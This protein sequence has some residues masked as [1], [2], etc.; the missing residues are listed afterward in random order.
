MCDPH[1]FNNNIL[2]LTEHKSKSIAF[3]QIAKSTYSKVSKSNLEKNSEKMDGILTTS[4]KIA[5]NDWKK[6]RKDTLWQNHF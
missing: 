3:L 2:L 1:I 5:K 4:S 6:M